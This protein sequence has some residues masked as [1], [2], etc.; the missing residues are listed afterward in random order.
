MY[1]TDGRYVSSVVPGNSYNAGSVTVPSIFSYARWAVGANATHGVISQLISGSTPSTGLYTAGALRVP[2]VFFAASGGV[3]PTAIVSDTQYYV[4]YQKDSGIFQVFA[5]AS[6]GSALDIS[7]GSAG[8]QYFNSF[9]PLYIPGNVTYVYS[10]QAVTLPAFETSISLGEVGIQLIIGCKGNTVYTWDQIISTVTATNTIF[11]PE[12]NVTNIV[13]VAQTAYLFAGNKG[14]IYVTNGTSASFAISVPDYCAGIAGIPQS[15]IEPYFVWGG[16]AYV[17]GRIYFSLLDQT[18]SKVGNCGGV[19]SFVPIQ[20]YYI[21][22]DVGLAL[23]LENQNS[24]GSYNGYATVILPFQDQAA[25]GVQYFSGWISSTSSPTYGI[26]FSGT[27]PT[28][29][30]VVETDFVPV[31]TMLRKTTFKQLEYKLAAPLSSGES[32]Q[33]YWRTDLTS[34]FTSAGSVEAETTTSDG[35]ATIISGLFTATFQNAQGLQLRCVQT[36]NGGSNVSFNRLLE[37]RAR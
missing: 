18:S 4:E 36:S 10:P 30:V 17:R 32:V 15:Y 33:L 1:I 19:W 20:N 13:T 28:S 29:T 3:L 14:N 22:Q 37:L 26:D 2:V 16:A 31:G 11:L 12:N 9:D 24:Y 25:R 35:S 7:T 6:G 27:V 34:A 5:A 21:E 8:V 23:R